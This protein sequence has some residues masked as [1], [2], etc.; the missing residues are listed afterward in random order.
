MGL[1]CSQQEDIIGQRIRINPAIENGVGGGSSE[2]PWLL[3]NRLEEQEERSS[4]RPVHLALL[5]SRFRSFTRHCWL[6]P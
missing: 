1:C 2:E 6:P 3:W 5:L 4:L